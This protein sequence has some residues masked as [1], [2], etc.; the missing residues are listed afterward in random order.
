MILQRIGAAAL[1][2]AAVLPAGSASA[3]SVDFGVAGS[4]TVYP[5]MG[6]CGTL[7]FARPVTAV[8]VFSSAGALSGPGTA[9]G[10]VRGAVPV[11]VVNATSWYG[12]LPDTYAG[13]TIGYATYTLTAST[14]DSDYVESRHCVVTSGRVT[15]T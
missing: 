12:C 8:G 9:V 3:V 1:V 13:A 7:T 11:T 15:C 5:D 10:V 2:A 6:A 14:A 4:I